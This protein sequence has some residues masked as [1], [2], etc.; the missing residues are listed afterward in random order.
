[1]P[2]SRLPRKIHSGSRAGYNSDNV[3]RDGPHHH[4]GSRHTTSKSQFRNWR[5]NI[6]IG[7]YP[8]RTGPRMKTFL[9]DATSFVGFPPKRKP[10]KLF[11]DLTQKCPKCHGHGGWNLELNAY[12]RGDH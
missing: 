7:K 6:D 2:E 4:H 10:T 12:G 5:V 9:K 3:V 8:G 11:P 1:M